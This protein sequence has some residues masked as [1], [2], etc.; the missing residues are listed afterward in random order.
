MK[1]ISDQLGREICIKTPPQRIVSLVPSQTELLCDLSLEKELVGITK[2]CVHPYH[3]KATKKIVGGTKKVDFEKIKAL[4]PDFILCNKEE[5]SY[6]FLPELE[7]IAPTYF[8]DVTTI[9]HALD[10]ISDLGQ[11]LNRRTESNNLIQ[12]INF[13]LTFNGVNYEFNISKN[14]IDI[15]ADKKS[16]VIVQGNERIIHA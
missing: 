7:K 9:Q 13:K 5:N 11:L 6:D 8:S 14:N 2:F 12:K 15:K 1:L 4:K 3:L 10:L 16:I